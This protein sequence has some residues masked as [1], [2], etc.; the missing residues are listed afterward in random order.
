MMTPFKIFTLLTYLLISSTT[1]VLAHI[2]PS[3][4]LS[5]TLYATKQ[6]TILT[7]KYYFAPELAKTVAQHVDTDQDGQ[8]DP[9]MQAI[10]QQKIINNIKI[11]INQQPTQLTFQNI[12]IPSLDKLINLHEPVV[13]TIKIDGVTLCDQANHLIEIHENNIFTDRNHDSYIIQQDKH[14]CVKSEVA[15]YTDYGLIIKTTS[16]L[17]SSIF[18]KINLPN[19]HTLTDILRTPHSNILPLTAIAF[20]LGVFHSLTPGHGKSLICTYL[21]GQ[22][23][24]I[25]DAISLGLIT[26]ITHTSTVFLLGISTLLAT[27]FINLESMT[28]KLEIISATILTLFGLHLLGKRARELKKPDRPPANS[29]TPQSQS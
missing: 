13:I 10:W 18:S 3:A 11:K 2:I 19:L 22:N 20:I 9:Q 24:K 7:I 25:R 21:V 12:L 28:Q 6:E 27:K 14:S 29:S 26:T 1:T 17:Q 8:T 16:Q 15:E 5:Y 4:T 23:G